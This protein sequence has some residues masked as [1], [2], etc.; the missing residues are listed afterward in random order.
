MDPKFIA[1]LTESSPSWPLPLRKRTAKAGEE[2]PVSS[3]HRGWEEIAAALGMCRDDLVSPVARIGIAQQFGQ[4]PVLTRMLL[5]RFGGEPWRRGGG[6]RNKVVLVAMWERVG[7]SRCPS[8]GG[9]VVPEESRDVVCGTCDGTGRVKWT[10]N[11]RCAALGVSRS[12]YGRRVHGLYGQVITTLEYAEGNL[13][14][15]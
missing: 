8:C 4:L 3:S 9:V 13:H 2:R 11:T 5:H 12:T 14:R 7:Q 1:K 10:W 6:W 15:L